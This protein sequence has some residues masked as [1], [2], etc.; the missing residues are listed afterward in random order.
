MLVLERGRDHDA[1]AE[2]RLPSQRDELRWGVRNHLAQDWSIETYTLR[3][4]RNETALPIRT[5]EAF[6]PGDGVGG[7]G[8]HW[9]GQCFRWAEYDPQLRTRLVDRY[10]AAAMPRDMPIQDWG[11]TYHELEPYHETFEKLF[12][13]A[14]KAGNLRGQIQE[15]GNPFEAPRRSE[16][17]QPP[18]EITEA[19]VIVS[20]AA[21]KLGYKPFPMAAS[22]SPH[23]YVNPDG[24]RLG[25]C[26]YCGH[27]ERFICESNAKGSPGSAAVPGA[28]AQART[29]RYVRT[30]TCSASTTTGRRSASRACAIST[31]ETGDEIEQPADVVVLSAFTFTNTKLL[32]LGRIGEPYDPATRRGVVGKNFCHQTNSSIN[33]FYK[34]RWINP[35]MAAGSSQTILDEFNGD[36]FDHTGLGFL[37]GA[38]IFNNTTNG[39]PIIDA[40]AAA[41][42]AAVGH[43]VEAGERRL[44]RARVQPRHDR[45]LLSARRKLPEPGSDVSRR[46]RPA[47]G[48]DHLR[49]ARQRSEDVRVRHAQGRRARER[50]RCDHRRSGRA[51]QGPVRRPSSI[52]RR[53]SSAAHPWAR[54]RTRAWCP[55]TCSTG[56][57]KT[58]SS[59]AARSTRTTP[60]TTRRH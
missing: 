31:C 39:R 38:Y 56:M 20:E 17:P 47:A 16:Y 49:L 48:A 24:M 50:E 15:G 6:L 41:G 43:E 18:L 60:A 14:G 58:C 26:Q 25:A 45:Q 7:A 19:G 34:D 35:F 32:L 23:V 29:S 12:G 11:V 4:S 3:H 51:A 59:S 28:Q 10:G 37:G 21:R 42:H 22:N 8:N 36:N 33:V 57:P 5:L 30:A 54:T 55:R 27:C 40:T 52:R 1:G 53:T 13:V 2:H 46:L 44:V 9:N